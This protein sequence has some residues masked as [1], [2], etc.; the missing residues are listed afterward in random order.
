MRTRLSNQYRPGDHL[1]TCDRCGFTIYASEARKEW[2]GLIVCAA[3]Y[4]QRHPQDLVR[5]KADKQSVKDSRPA[6][7]PVYLTTNQVTADS[8]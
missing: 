4:D 1:V 8:L 7:E 2:T 6:P 5:A 3:D